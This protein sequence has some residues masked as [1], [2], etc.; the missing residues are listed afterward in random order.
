[1][2]KRLFV[3][4]VDAMVQED[5]D[6][7]RAKPGSDFAKFYEN[8]CGLES[9]R[10][11]YPSIT[12]PVHVS[13]QTGCYP[14]KT[15]IYTNYVFSTNEVGRDWTWDA[16]LIRTDNIFAAAKR[17]GYSTAAAFWPVT[18][19]DPDID[20]HLPEYWLAHPGETLRGAFMERGASEEVARLIEK[21]AHLL[22]EGYERGGM[23][24]VAKEPEFDDFMIHVAC[25]MIREHKP[26]VMFLHASLIDSLRHANGIFCPEVTA[27]L[28]LVDRWLGMLFQAHRDAGT[29]DET[30]FVIL[31]DHGQNDYAREVRPN[32][33]LARRG[34]IQVDGQGRVTDY[35]VYGMHNGLSMAF[36]LKDPGDR[37]AY[38]EAYAVLKEMAAEG[39]YGFTQVLTREEAAKR[40]HLD[41]DF[42][43]IIEGDG[44]TS[45][46][47]QCTGPGVVNVPLKNYRMG[48]GNHGHMPDV[49]PQPVFFAKGPD[50]K[51]NVMLPRRDIVDEGPTFARLLGVELRDAQGTAMTQLLKN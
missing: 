20:F 27:G 14:E 25:D 9:V 51:E 15:G 46:T 16:R 49:G 37:A 22:P 42:A 19:Y 39:L 12:Y 8:C 2:K 36:W 4:S 32:V 1:M 3:L 6:Y 26:E 33:F 35:K 47:D 40:F 17:G 21:H 23:A 5:A 43:F 10:T 28:D 30:N 29:F 24:N 7:L 38:D 31:S 13:I 34:L 48:K 50:F 18:S 11:I 45:F 44:Y 41:G